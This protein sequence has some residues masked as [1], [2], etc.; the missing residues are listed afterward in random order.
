MSPAVSNHF[1]NVS[2]RR[3]DD[4]HIQWADQAQS[5]EPPDG[6][7]VAPHG[8]RCP[9]AVDATSRILE[10]IFAHSACG[11]LQIAIEPLNDIIAARPMPSRAPA[12][13]G[14]RPS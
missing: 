7:Q 14:R 12:E 5:A 13:P 3:V 8:P 10:T 4:E 9:R 2:S 11:Q 1:Q 6:A